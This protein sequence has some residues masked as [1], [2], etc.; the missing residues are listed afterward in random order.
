MANIHLK[1][2]H[3]GGYEEKT[4]SVAPNYL[5]G[6]LSCNVYMKNR[7]ARLLVHIY[8]HI[9]SVR[10]VSLVYLLLHVLKH[11]IHGFPFVLAKQKLL[12][13]PKPRIKSYD[14]IIFWI[15]PSFFIQFYWN[16]FFCHTILQGRH[17]TTH[18]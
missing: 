10:M 8:A 7:L 15:I 4:L 11:H 12:L 14:I 16:N 9:V 5:M 6:H 1:I 3:I 2:C 18:S 17:P 13:I